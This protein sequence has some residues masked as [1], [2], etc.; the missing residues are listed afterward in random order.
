[1]IRKFYLQCSELPRFYRFEG[2]NSYNHF[3][4]SNPE[5]LKGTNQYI[6]VS[7]TLKHHCFYVSKRL[8]QLINNIMLKGT[9]L[10]LKKSSVTNLETFKAILKIVGSSPTGEEQTSIEFT[11]SPLFSKLL[12][13]NSIH[14]SQKNSGE[15]YIEKVDL[16]RS[17]GGYGFTEEWLEL[18]QFFTYFYVHQRI[19]R[20]DL[21]NFLYAYRNNIVCGSLQFSKVPF[22]LDLEKKVIEENPNM[23]SSF[24]KYE[25]M[26]ILERILEKKLYLP[27]SF[28]GEKQEDGIKQ[29]VAEYLEE[30]EAMLEVQEYIKRL[31]IMEENKKGIL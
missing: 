22:L 30:K 6:Y 5:F 12:M 24:S 17:G 1:M 10:S 19:T 29:I 20:T 7:R 3:N 9:G 13:N 14:S 2:T 23:A 18:F 31:S 21:I 28:L 25:L 15:L 8:R 16:K 4:F 11:I 26:D 27:N